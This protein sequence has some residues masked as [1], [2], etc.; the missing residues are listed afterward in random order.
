MRVGRQVGIVN[1]AVGRILG[2]LDAA[3]V[4]ATG[5]PAWAAGAWVVMGRPQLAQKLA[6]ALAWP[7]QYGQNL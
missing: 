5:V 6:V 7:P 3:P 4:T 2:Q 1:H